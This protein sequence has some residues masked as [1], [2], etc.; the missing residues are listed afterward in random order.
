MSTEL[1]WRR[2]MATTRLPVPPEALWPLLGSTARINEAARMLPKYTLTET[3]NPDGSVLQIGRAQSRLFQFEWEE[4]PVEWLENHVQRQR[5]LFRKGPF[6]AVEITI[7]LEPDADG[8][9]VTYDV[10]AYPANFWGRLGLMTGYLDRQ[11]AVIGRLVAEAGAGSSSGTG[12][13]ASFTLPPPDLPPLARERAAAIVLRLEADGH[14]LARR[15]A[16]HLLDAGEVELEKLRPLALARDWGEPPRP[17]IEL[18]L[19]A[20]KAG[21]L[22]LRW[23]LLCPRCRGAKA[24]VPSLDQL[25]RTAHCPS[26][27][28]GYDRDFTRN[29][30][31][32]FEPATTIRPLASGSFCLTG[33]HSTPHVAVQQVLEPGERRSLS[34]SLPA[35]DY[36]IRTREIGGEVDLTVDDGIC[37]AINLAGAEVTLSGSVI[38][39]IEVANSGA[40]R[41]TLV[42]ERR[43]WVRD[44]LTAQRATTLQA[45]RDLFATE[46]LRPGDEVGIE[47]ISLLFTDLKSSTALYGRLGDAAAYRLVREH[48]AVL[49]AL[50][51]DHDGAVVK[52]IGDAVMAAFSDPAAAVRV[53]LAIQTT[54][55]GIEATPPLVIKVGV[56]AGPCIAVTL[57]DRLDYF[58]TTVNLAARLQQ[59]SAG[60][61]VV[62]SASLAADPAVAGLLAG[63]VFLAETAV[64]RGFGLPVELVRV[65]G[66]GA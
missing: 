45:F 66:D 59:Q 19:A 41:R 48:Y 39:K 47:Q 16:G 63:H 22:V 49:A 62:L 18:C 64:L 3:A 10:A 33:P 31:L 13:A 56:H 2:R 23:D 1:P 35:G 55:A 24:S 30:E 11:L 8:S 42:I 60:G 43:D 15:L 26:G 36:R 61:D 44:A 29:V 14:P 21:L 12:R 6:G 46:S 52:T 4:C 58:G 9:R 53:A 32:V 37:P 7:R 54:A 65:T 50:V 40:V 20:V 17:V 57:N 5:R 38:G 27:N 51:R 34:Y 28:I 25:P